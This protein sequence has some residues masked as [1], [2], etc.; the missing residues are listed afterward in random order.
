MLATKSPQLEKAVGVLKELSADERTRMLAEAREK[1]RRDE[2]S[3]LNRAKRE[4]REEILELLKN[5]KSP[6][7]II[8][9]YG[10]E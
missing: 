8:R 6:E 4:G 10:A 3:R 7:E 1:A 2:V 9:E 5:G